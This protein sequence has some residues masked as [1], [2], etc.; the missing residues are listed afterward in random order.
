VHLD[1]V[2]TGENYRIT[3]V[4]SLL[5]AGLLGLTSASL[6]ITAMMVHTWRSTSTQTF[7]RMDEVR[8]LVDRAVLLRDSG[9]EM[10]QL[11]T[12]SNEDIDGWAA[13]YKVRYSEIRENA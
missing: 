8:L 9:A 3:I 1:S 11:P 2:G 6:I 4:P 7:Q 10:V 12:E 13:G 5:F